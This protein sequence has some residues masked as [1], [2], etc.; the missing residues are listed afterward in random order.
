MIIA[1]VGAV[2][3]LYG[4][5]GALGQRDIKRVLAYSTIS[6]VG[7]MVLAVGAADIIGGMFHLLSHAFFKSL[8]FLTAGYVIQ[9]LAEEHDIFKM[10]NL[11]RLLPHIYWPF[12]IGALALSAFPMVGG[13]FS[14]DR[15]LLAT[16]VYPGFSYK[17]FWVLAA[18]AAFI[19]PLYTFRLFF[20]VFQERPGG[21]TPEE[22]KPVP[23]FMAYILWPLAGLALLDGMLNLPFGPGKEWLGHY[24]STLPGS[25][26]DIGAPLAYELGM[27]VGSALVVVAVIILTYYLYRPPGPTFSAPGWQALLFEAFYLDKFYQ[28]LIVRPYRRLATFW[29]QAVDEGGLDRGLEGAA[30]GVDLLSRGLGYWTTGRLSTYVKMLLVGLTAFFAALALRWYLW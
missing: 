15:I 22:I 24:L 11:R 10:G 6:Q 27:G 30:G 9:A 2:T 20:L 28:Y 4:A 12:L 16:F 13:F 17:V 5:A 8:L 23:N 1:G 21:R 3:T 7:Y 18:A 29:W 14:K 25:R 26:V 19:T